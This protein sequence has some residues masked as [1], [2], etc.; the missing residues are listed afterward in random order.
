MTDKQIIERL[1]IDLDFE[2]SKRKTLQSEL[3]AKEQECEELKKKVY[4]YEQAEKYPASFLW[5]EGLL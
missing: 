1:K 3:T 2:R 5:Q 4:K